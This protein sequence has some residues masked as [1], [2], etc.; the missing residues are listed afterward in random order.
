MLQRLGVANPKHILQRFLEKRCPKLYPRK[1]LQR[2]PTKKS[3]AISTIATILG[4]LQH[5]SCVE[6]G[7][8]F[9]SDAYPIPMPSQ[10]K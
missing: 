2:L 6:T 7:S 9:S 5:F 4:L 10:N 8:K 1:R 3:V